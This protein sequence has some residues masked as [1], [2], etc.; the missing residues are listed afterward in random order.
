MWAFLRN[1]LNEC[2]PFLPFQRR[3]LANLWRKGPTDVLRDFLAFFPSRLQQTGSDRFLNLR[4]DELEPLV[5]FI[6]SRPVG[7]HGAILLENVC[8]DN[9]REPLRFHPTA[10]DE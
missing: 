9:E 8:L 3:E 7:L 4:V 2:I 5:V 1:L 10:I 6:E